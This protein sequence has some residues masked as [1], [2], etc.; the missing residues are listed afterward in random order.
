MRHLVFLSLRLETQ[1][2][3][4]VN[5]PSQVV[6]TLH[7]IAQFTEDLTDLVFDRVG[8]IGSG[9][10]ALQVRKKLVFHKVNQV[11]SGQGFVVVD[12][13]VAIAWCCPGFPLILGSDDRLIG[14]AHQLSG[15][16]L[17]LL[18]VVEVFKEEDPG[19]LL[20]IIE[21]AAAAGILP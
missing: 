13:A 15:E 21:L 5:D 20:D 18:E 17:L 11:G 9:R 8:I 10:E 12:L 3:Y 6:A 2:V 19:S 16:L 1:L 7:F 14:L 4:Q